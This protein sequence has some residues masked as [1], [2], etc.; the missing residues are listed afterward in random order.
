MAKKR[1]SIRTAL[2]G[3]ARPR[4]LTDTA[5][6]LTS[7]LVSN[8]VK[9]SDG[10]VSVRLRSHPDA[11]RIGVM[12]NRPELPDPLPCT[13]DQDFGRGLCLVDTLADAWGRYPLTA[14]SRTPSWKV[15]WFELFALRE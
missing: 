6:L 11:V 10:P 5:E 13:T 9:H 8:A 12:D 2:L 4:E 14:P 3:P 7:E 1:E 15:V